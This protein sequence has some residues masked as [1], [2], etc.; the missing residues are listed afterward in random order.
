ML[1]APAARSSRSRSMSRSTTSSRPVALSSSATMPASM[2]A[3]MLGASARIASQLT[4]PRSPG[5]RG[6]Q[7]SPAGSG[8]SSQPRAVASATEVPVAAS[9]AK[10]TAMAPTSSAGRARKW[11]VRRR[12]TSSSSPNTSPG[13]Q[14][15][16]VSASSRA[17]RLAGVSGRSASTPTEPL[18]SS[19]PV[20]ARKPPITG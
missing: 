6:R 17:G 1:A 5:P 20:P 10:N 15:A 11:L 12:I 16:T 8:S 4:W 3:S 7:R 18:S 2:I 19:Q 9:R 14:R 13:S